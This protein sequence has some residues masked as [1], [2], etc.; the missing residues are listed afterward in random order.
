MPNFE[1]VG[2]NPP[3]GG[4]AVA[5][6]ERTAGHPPSHPPSGACRRERGRA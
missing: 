3:A 1:I 2:A 5:A 6:L 4:A